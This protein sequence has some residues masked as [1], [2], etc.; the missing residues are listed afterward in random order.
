M[1]VEI[2]T[3]VRSGARAEAIFNLTVFFD[4]VVSGAEIRRAMMAKF[5]VYVGGYVFRLVLR[6]EQLDVHLEDK[7]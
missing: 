7:F 1:S 3:V 4:T 2:V 5:N 6:A